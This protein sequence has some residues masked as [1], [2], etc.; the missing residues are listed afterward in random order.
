MRYALLST[1]CA[2][3]LFCATA[4]AQ[5]AMPTFP[6]EDRFQNIVPASSEDSTTLGAGLG[7][8]KIDEDFFLQIAPTFDINLGA[9]GLGVHVPLNLRIIDQE[10]KNDRDFGGV[11]RRED[12]DEPAEFLKAIR[13]VRMGHKRD[14]LYLR[15]GQI[16]AD[17]G[18][19]TIVSRYINN[20]DINQVRLGLQLDLNSKYGGVETMLADAGFVIG[21]S[22]YKASKLFALR[23]YV[24]PVAFADPDS[25]LN[26]FQVGASVAVDAN[27]PVQV[28]CPACTVP[29]TAKS[30]AA[31]VFGF[32]IEAEVL[33]NAL[34]DL[35]P[36]TDLNFISG[37]G[38]GLHLG[39]LATLKFPIIFE[40]TVPVRLEYRHFRSNYVPAYFS[41]FYE[42]ERFNVALNT[43]GVALPKLRMVRNLDNTRGIN[44]YYGDLAFDFAGILQVGGVYEDYEGS[45]GGNLE[46][47]VGV[48]AL[49]FLKFKAYYKR[50]QI[51][52]GRDV[53][54]LD[55]KS[56]LVAEARYEVVTYVW[57][58]GR[59][60]RRWQLDT[61]SGSV[62]STDDWK[63]GAE[64]AIN[65]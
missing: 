25:L 60:T 44:G 8:R 4:A 46:L 12:W 61:N 56:M 28:E 10:P 35:V 42:L 48:P 13:Y 16:A 45:N 21:G 1:T 19:G 6:G 52:D 59:F 3:S 63:I 50:V 27:A 26:I 30:K 40:V 18:H 31:T 49:D 20:T 43:D 7:F 9:V 39:V 15:A 17:I 51:E 2:A 14:D 11:I 62:D 47:F 22:G 34:V 29:T 33:S 58:V 57:L 37:A 32:D 55:E 38:W 41:T 54:A 64:M 53:F 24:K 23:T 65:F 36:Y 5:T